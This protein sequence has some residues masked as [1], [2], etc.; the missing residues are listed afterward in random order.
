[1]FSIKDALPYLIELIEKGGKEP[2][3]PHLFVAAMGVV[4]EFAGILCSVIAVSFLLVMFTEIAKRALERLKFSGLMLGSG[5]T[6][7]TISNGVI[8]WSSSGITDRG[9][10]RQRREGCEVA[11]AEGPKGKAEHG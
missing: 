2:L 3:I 7:F 5:T 9:R 4:N 10:S 11:E 8:V 1:L 6:L